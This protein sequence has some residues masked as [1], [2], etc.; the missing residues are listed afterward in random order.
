MG[1]ELD[2]VSRVTAELMARRNSGRLRHLE[3]RMGAQG[4]VI[5]IQDRR[6]LN[7]TSNDYLGLAAHPRVVG[8]VRE[9]LEQHGF[10]SGSAA[11]LSGRSALHAEFE[12]QLAVYLG[13]DAALL[14]SS[15]Y[16]ANLGAIAALAGPR[17]LILHDRLN[18][19]SLI[20]AVRASGARHKRYRH[21]DVGAVA[22][23]LRAST[24]GHKWLVTESVFSMD[25]DIAPLYALDVLCQDHG[26]IFYIDDAHGF[27]V[28]EQGRGA[29]H[30]LSPVRRRQAVVMVTLGKAMGSVGAAILADGA[31]IEFLIQRARTFVYDTALP[32]VCAAAALEALAI[33][34]ADPALPQLLAANVAYF[35]SRA[36]VAGVPLTA[37][38]TPIQP[39]LI[40][41]DARAVAIAEALIVDGIYVRAIRPPTVPAGTARLRITLTAAHGKQA[42]DALVEALSRQLTR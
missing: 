39:I 20:D 18:H 1:V 3:S 12:R 38:T 24:Q 32:P 7:F 13:M 10:G 16:M 8:R 23:Q 42:I 37:S 6:L 33:V 19:A 15:G 22:E 31:V 28:L 30:V 29:V 2:L 11:L 41:D 34:Q 9:E 35:R 17:D 36:A 26:T 14:F 25:G 27:G 4:E 40:G 21:L 5:T